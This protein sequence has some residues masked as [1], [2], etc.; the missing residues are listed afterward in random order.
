MCRRLEAT[1]LTRDNS[2]ACSEDDAETSLAHF[3]IFVVAA[4]SDSAST[5]HAHGP[6][7][8]V[9]P[10][11]R[12]SVVCVTRSVGALPISIR[13]ARARCERRGRLSRLSSSRFSQIR[14]GDPPG[15]RP[16]DNA[17]SAFGT[18]RSDAERMRRSGQAGVSEYQFLDSGDV[19]R[20]RQR[21][22]SA[23]LTD[24]M[25]NYEQF[26]NW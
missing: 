13:K 2:N 18:R 17:R 11:D 23:D 10:H 5:R 3:P 16:S 6:V 15:P 21:F 8:T 19:S 12:Q 4:C 25:R 22:V 14:R 7:M 9:A 1:E 20:I 26:Q 24:S